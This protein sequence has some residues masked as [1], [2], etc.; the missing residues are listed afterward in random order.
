MTG[1]QTCALP[2]FFTAEDIT[3]VTIEATWTDDGATL[4]SPNDDDYGKNTDTQIGIIENDTDRQIT[5]PVTVRMEQ[6]V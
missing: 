6:H 5:I 1:V 4:D 2:I 3:T